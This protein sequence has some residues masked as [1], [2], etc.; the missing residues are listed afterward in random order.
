MNR[1]RLNSNRVDG[2]IGGRSDDLLVRGS[3]DLV[4]FSVLRTRSCE[5]RGYESRNDECR[6]HGEDCSKSVV[7]ALL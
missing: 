5:S 3:T 2:D 1:C 7:M 4:P 6:T